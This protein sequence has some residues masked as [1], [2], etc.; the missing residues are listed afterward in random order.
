MARPTGSAILYLGL[1]F[2]SGVLVG[3]LGFRAFTHNPNRPPETQRDGPQQYE[4]YM[5]KRLGLRPDQVVQFHDILE[6]TGKKFREVREKFR[7]EFE[8][9]Q[10]DQTESIK[11]ILDDQQKAEYEKLRAEREKERMRRSGRPPR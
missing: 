2:L 9:L 8:A 3:G 6:R 11:S 4:E 10:K 7:P 5:R 1:V